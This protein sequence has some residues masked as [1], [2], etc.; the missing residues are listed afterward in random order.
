MLKKRTNYKR[1]MLFIN[2]FLLFVFL[3]ELPASASTATA[4]GRLIVSAPEVALA[5]FLIAVVIFIVRAI[6]LSLRGK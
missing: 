4:F 3:H 1:I 5:I 6:V 2:S